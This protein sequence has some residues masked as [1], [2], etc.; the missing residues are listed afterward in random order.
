[1]PRIVTNKKVRNEDAFASGN[2]PVKSS[3]YY[4]DVTAPPTQQ[5][6]AQINANMIQQRVN[7]QR[8]NYMY[9][10]MSGQNVMAMEK[11]MKRPKQDK[12]PE[13][14]PKVAAEVT[15][16]KAPVN[17]AE[18]SNTGFYV[19]SVVTVIGF[20]GFGCFLWSKKLKTHK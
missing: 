19:L 8:M 12:E 20:I 15:T 3:T 18:T 7:A 9:G 10:M 11:P 5:S 4:N 16:E 14:E 6:L 1:M 13:Q 2:T 17:T